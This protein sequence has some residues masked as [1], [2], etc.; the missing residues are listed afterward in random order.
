ME[1]TPAEAPK[2][3]AISFSLFGT[4]NS[5]DSSSSNQPNSFNGGSKPVVS[6]L[7]LKPPSSA[8]PATASR[9]TSLLQPSTSG[10][11]SITSN[12]TSSTRHRASN[13]EVREEVSLSEPEEPP[14]ESQVAEVDEEDPFDSFMADIEETAEQLKQESV[15]RAAT[16]VSTSS[17]GVNAEGKGEKEERKEGMDGEE[18]EEASAMA[19]M[20]DIKKLA[21]VNVRKTLEAVD[22]SQ[23]DYEAFTKNFYIEV[24]EISKMSEEQVSEYRRTIDGVRIRGKSCPRPV[25]TF[26]QSGLPGNILDRLKELKFERPTPIQAQALPAI[27]SGRDVI[28]IAKTGSGKTLA[29]ALPLMRHIL[30]QR[31]L[32]A[33]EG[34]IALVMVPTRELAN[35]ISDDFHLF[36]RACGIVS[37]CIYGGA[38]MSSQIADLKRG[39]HIVVCT[40]GRMIEMLTLGRVTNLKRVT[41]M[42]IDEADRMFDLGF[43]QQIM[44][45]VQNV[46]PDRQTVMFSATFPRQVEAAARKILSSNPL[47]I[48]VHGRSVVSNTI[49]QI[50]QII[51]HQKKFIKLMEIISEWYSK[52]SILVFAESQVAVDMLFHNVIKSGYDALSFHAGRDQADRD[53]TIERFKSGDLRILIATSGASRGL[54]VPGLKLV[55]NYDV[56]NHLEDYVHRVG[57]T[58]RAG[59]LGTAITFISPDEE[60]FAG[61]ILKALKQST[62]SPNIPDQLVTM[63]ANFEEKQ[64]K[65][66]ARKHASGFVGKGYQFSEDEDK[67]RKTAMN[68]IKLH[69]GGDEAEDSI[70][71]SNAAASSNADDDDDSDEDADKNNDNARSSTSA[72][73]AQNH[74][75]TLNN[76]SNQEN[77]SSNSSNA[78]NLPAGADRTLL[79]ALVPES[80][81]AKMTPQ[82]RTA[83]EKFNSV[84]IAKA[85]LQS[86]E[87][88]NLSSSGVNS[89]SSGSSGSKNVTG[90]QISSS[91]GASG[92][93]KSPDH[94]QDHHFD[95]VIEINDFP[96]QVR[97]RVTSKETFADL[98]ELTGVAITPK[99]SYVAP[100]KPVP[101]G[102]RKLYLSIEGPSQEAITQARNGIK[103]VLESA[104]ASFNLRGDRPVGRY[105]VD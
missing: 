79:E 33:G 92:R 57:R 35:Q 34:P 9:L 31:D 46:R 24:P 25:K 76:N 58:G 50:V 28:G 14:Q 32:S 38:D 20:D 4:S 74:G 63:A 42:V 26:A 12:L 75:N 87:S 64:K 73:Q 91:I 93:P 77:P 95:D 60:M 97:R 48:T 55:V 51:E 80:E 84:L 23:I 82:Q 6:S 98:V 22:H 16:I 54:D 2:P 11:P 39:A 36:R 29:F 71:G 18:G 100:G 96:Q 94:Q 8:P 17:T 52:G 44:K 59:Q 13:G 21:Q 37:C 78:L 90:N 27:M 56:P 68:N 86:Q 41:F 62:N 81:L 43:E 66:L 3:S 72:S 10:K 69:F 15:K 1:S 70:L 45:I 65:G 103:Q 53:E 49:T 85:Q 104:M 83:A 101:A 61:D 89:S 99:G 19:T 40:P 105:H 67:L 30:A 47:E 88:S 5:S 102:E 7:L